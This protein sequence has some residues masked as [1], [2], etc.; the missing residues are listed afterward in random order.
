MLQ[1][2]DYRSVLVVNLV[3]VFEAKV[4]LELLAEVVPE[5][6]QPLP[7][8]GWNALVVFGC[9]KEAGQQVDQ[10]VVARHNVHEE[11]VRNLPDLEQLVNLQ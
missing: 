5:L 10:E 7:Q 11:V 4:P 1:F 9:Q 2:H 3:S 8:P 6:V